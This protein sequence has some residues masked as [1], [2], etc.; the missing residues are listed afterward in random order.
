M[1][2]CHTEGWSQELEGAWPFTCQS[3]GSSVVF[4]VTLDLVVVMFWEILGMEKEKDRGT[5]PNSLTDGFLVLSVSFS[6]RS[7]YGK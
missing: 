1:V 6:R 7:V 3:G 5:L 4:A 2:H